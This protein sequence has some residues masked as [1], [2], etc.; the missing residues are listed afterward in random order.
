MVDKDKSNNIK[1]F[2]LAVL[3]L[4]ALCGLG[5]G[6]YKLLS[7]DTPAPKKI[8]VVAIEGFGKTPE[9]AAAAF[10]MTAGNMGKASDVNF[11]KLDN[12]SA[13]NTNYDRRIDSYRKST[14]GL[15]SG[16]RLI[17][18]NQETY[19]DEYSMT[20]PWAEYY[21]IDP[22]SIAV[23][24]A[25]PIDD[26][27]IDRG[28][29]SSEYKASTVTASFFSTKYHFQPTSN[30]VD[31]DGSFVEIYNEQLFEDVEFTLV[32]VSENSWR[33]Y[34]FTQEVEIGERFSTWDTQA[35][36]GINHENDTEGDRLT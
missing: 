35:K 9:E 18:E 23:S 26:I 28:N 2:G 34:D 21:E 10:I 32:E 14:E 13:V 36:S 3:S 29:E 20:R 4:V 5:F 30:D 19:I 11:E 16:S 1:T 24:K 7:D 15:V 12:R 6:A 22:D 27:S 33:I 17:I 8:E 31:A 25:T